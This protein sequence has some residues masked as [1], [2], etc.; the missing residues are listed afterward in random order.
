MRKIGDL[1]T[2]LGIVGFIAIVLEFV[3]EWGMLI[4]SIILPFVIGSLLLLLVGIV[5]RSV[6]KKQKTD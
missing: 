1:L 2:A 4:D 6:G 5:L 3:M